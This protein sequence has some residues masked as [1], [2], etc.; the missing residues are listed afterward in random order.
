M[1]LK[2]P[3]YA[4]AVVICVGFYY[5]ISMLNIGQELLL[6]LVFGAIIAILLHPLVALFE[7]WKFNR[8]LA[9]CITFLLSIIVIAA[10][11]LFLYSQLGKFSESWPVFVDRFTGLINQT[12]SRIPDI[13]GISADK[14]N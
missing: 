7:K 9:I 14:V 5:F 13:S 6:P 10:C 11:G 1:Q 3:V 2:L 4:K 8:V 12:I